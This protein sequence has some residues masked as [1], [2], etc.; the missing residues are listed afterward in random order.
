MGPLQ[1]PLAKFLNHRFMFGVKIRQPLI[2]ELLFI[3]VEG[4]AGVELSDFHGGEAV[5]PR[6]LSV[7]VEALLD[8]L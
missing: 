6:L 8:S 3:K 5:E 2:F 1:N 4:T 7:P